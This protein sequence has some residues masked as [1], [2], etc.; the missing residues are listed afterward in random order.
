[1]IQAA[2]PSAQVHILTETPNDLIRHLPGCR[3]ILVDLD[4]PW[5][6]DRWLLGGL[7]SFLPRSTVRWSQ[8]F[9]TALCDWSPA[10]LGTLMTQR[11]RV[12][13]S[14]PS[15]FRHML[16][17]IN[18]ADIVL[19]TG[20]GGL[21]NVETNVLQTLEIASALHKPTAMLGLGLDGQQSPWL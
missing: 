21:R 2:E 3:P 4:W 7:H 16:E 12:A 14:N 8:R 19:V 9:R 13:R 11:L 18:S 10:L 5:Y 15:A 17:T 1:R 6:S 20:L